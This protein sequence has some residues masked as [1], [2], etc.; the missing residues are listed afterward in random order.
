MAQLGSRSRL[1]GLVAGAG[2]LSLLLGAVALVVAPSASANQPV[3]AVGPQADPPGNNGTIKIEGVDMQ[4]GPPDNN[5][6]QGCTFVVEFYNYDKGNFDASVTFEDQPPT[7]DGGL[8]VVSGDLTP[9]IGEDAAGGGN[10]LDAK[11][12][13]TLAFTGQPHPVQGYHVK[14][15]VHAMGSQGADVKHKVFWVIGCAAPPTTPPTSAPTKSPTHPATVP[16]KPTTAPTQPTS[17]PIRP[18]TAPTR[19]ATSASQ[20]PVTDTSVPSTSSTPTTGVPTEV[21]AGL[22]GGPGLPVA[23]SN[24]MFGRGNG[25]LFGTAGGI[26]LAAGGMLLVIGLA[27][28][29]RRRSKHSI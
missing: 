15:T 25:I 13:Y 17:A 20:T 28:A 1:P 24:G 29:L 5:P 27:I 9:F 7:A 12:T 22:G 10:D 14:I 6:H 2:A 3:V 26:L 23:Q 16:T 8:Q 21:D 4:S 19:P 11:E 18:T